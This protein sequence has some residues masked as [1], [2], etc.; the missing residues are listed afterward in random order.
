L[1]T[2]SGVETANRLGYERAMFTPE[3]IKLIVEDKMPGSRVQVKDLTG[4]QDHFELTIVS[5][6]FEGKGLVDRHRMVYAMFGSAVGAEIHALSLKTF[7]PAEY[8]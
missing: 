5:K 3:K 2:S 1:G 6:E 4:T 7:T 8:K